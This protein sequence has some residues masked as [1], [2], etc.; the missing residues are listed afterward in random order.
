[1]ICMQWHTGSKNYTT[2]VNRLSSDNP[3]PYDNHKI[4]VLVFETISTDTFYDTLVKSS[5]GQERV[6]AQKGKEWGKEKDSE[7]RKTRKT[8][9]NNVY[10]GH[11]IIGTEHCFEYGIKSGQPRENGEVRLSLKMVKMPGQSMVQSCIPILN[12]IQ[13]DMLKL[14][15]AKANAAPPGLAINIDSISNLKIGGNKLS[16]MTI[17]EIR[18]TKGDLLFK[19]TPMGLSGFG[20][21]LG[22]P[23]EE[24]RGG[25]GELGVE[26][27]N[28]I[29]FRIEMLRDI[30]GINQ[31]ADASTPDPNA[32]VRGSE[33]ALH[34]TNNAIRPL[35]KAYM[36][37]KELIALSGCIR[38]QILLK[39][40]PEAYE[41]YYPVLGKHTLKTLQISEKIVRTNY[42]IKVEAAPTEK[43]KAE[44]DNYITVAMQSGKNGVPLI[45]ASHGLL[46]KEMTA[47]NVPLKSV[48]VMISFLEN[49]ERQLNHQME[50]ERV[51]A[52]GEEKRKSD[53]QAF[54]ISKQIKQNEAMLAIE[55]DNNKS[56]NKI[57]EIRAEKMFE[58]T[59]TMP[60]ESEFEKRIATVE[61]LLLRAEQGERI[62]LESRLQRETSNVN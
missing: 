51:Q 19:V 46:L 59:I 60:A 6:Y 42:A 11:L 18:R 38:S 29:K 47:S 45:R 40:F 54:E 23:M 31:V 58:A 21:N 4:K 41:A 37:L 26:L 53:I 61:S 57:Q 3:T 43:Q 44:L 50:I 24:L 1:M 8:Q 28:D 49:K 10:Y 56:K 48:R 30:T 13:L 7:K 16:P 15:N 39:N 17:L 33:L 14:Q 25:L 62:A 9:I 35:Y 27:L 32:S 34:A 36:N 5:Y 12:E 2:S 55:I 52:Q 22:K 20:N